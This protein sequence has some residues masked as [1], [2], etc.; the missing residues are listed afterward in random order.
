MSQESKVKQ[1]QQQQQTICSI[2]VTFKKGTEVAQQVKI[3]ESELP[4]MKV[5]RIYKAAIKGFAARL[6]LDEFEKL[7][8]ELAVAI[9]TPIAKIELDQKIHAAS[10]NSS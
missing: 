3:L 1:R 8:N 9:D 7:V 4:N 10:I 5:D 2:I 6:P